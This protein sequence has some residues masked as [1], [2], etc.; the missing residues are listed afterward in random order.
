VPSLDEVIHR[1]GTMMTEANAELEK[2]YSFCMPPIRAF[3]PL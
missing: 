1:A 3:A 2:N